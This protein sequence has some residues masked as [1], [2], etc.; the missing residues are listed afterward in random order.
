V[1]LPAGGPGHLDD[2]PPSSQVLIVA[3]GEE[4][5]PA[6]TWGASFLARVGREEG[7]A[8]P[9]GLPPTW[10]DEHAERVARAAPVP[11]AELDDE[12]EEDL[13]EDE[14]V[15]PQAFFLVRDLAPLPRSEWVFSN[16]LVPKQQRRG[17]TFV[18]RVP[19]LITLPD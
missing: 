14:R 8:L 10:V 4:T 13:D 2:V 1:I 17:R 15:G 6:A 12:D 7:D 19:T 11:G 3:T 5:V 16:E 9:E 18:P